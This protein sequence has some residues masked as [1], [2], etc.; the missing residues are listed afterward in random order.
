M[1]DTKRKRNVTWGKVCEAVN[2]VGRTHKFTAR[3]DAE[4]ASLRSQ[5]E[6]IEKVLLDN[7]TTSN[8]TQMLDNLTNMRHSVASLETTRRQETENSSDND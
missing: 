4:I 2:R 1:M 8:K 3:K 6:A 7:P 5:I